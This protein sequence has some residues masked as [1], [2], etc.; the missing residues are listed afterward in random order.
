VV[1]GFLFVEQFAF[2]PNVS[3][4]SH[5]VVASGLTYVREDNKH[6]GKGG[7][8]RPE[9]VGRTGGSDGM[10]FSDA[11][12]ATLNQIDRSGLF[13]NSGRPCTCGEDAEYRTRSER[14]YSDSM[15]YRHRCLTCG[16]TFSTFTEG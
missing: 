4:I 8:I 6:T 15:V 12:Q 14:K 3:G 16:H 13:L 1:V 9:P 5:Y 11:E 2:E 10:G 7:F